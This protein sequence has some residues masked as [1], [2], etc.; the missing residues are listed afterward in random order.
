VQV[1]CLGCGYYVLFSCDLVDVDDFR[2]LRL[3]LSN[4]FKLSLLHEDVKNSPDGQ[5]LITLKVSERLLVP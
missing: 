3:S 5:N 2:Y 4:V 1:I